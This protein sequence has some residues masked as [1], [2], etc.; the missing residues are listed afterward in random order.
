MSEPAEIEPG[1]APAPVEPLHADVETWVEHV[2]VK[3]FIRPYSQNERRWCARWWAHPEA[4]VRL[5]ALWETWEAAR[6]AEDPH[7]MA[8][9]LWRY[10]DTLNAVLLGPEGPFASCSPDKHVEQPPMHTE[11]A[12]AGYWDR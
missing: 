12:P 3:T 6:A 2:Y 11:P 7:P 1:G 5:T 9:W 8:D 10:L 4:I